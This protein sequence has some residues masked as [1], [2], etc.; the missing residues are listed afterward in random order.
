MHAHG[1]SHTRVPLH[2]LLLILALP[3]AVWPSRSKAEIVLPYIISDGMVLQRDAAVA[4]WG[5][6]GADARLRVSFHGISAEARA[7]AHGKWSLRL[8]PMRAAGDPA[9]LTITS[10]D[11]R[12]AARRIENVLVGDVWLC[13]GQ[14]NMYCP[15]GKIAE[16]PGAEGGE[17]AI[18][19]PPD[20]QLRLIC[21]DQAPLWKQRGWQP[22]SP[23]SRFPF[24]AVAYFFGARLRR[25]LNVPIGL[26]NVS[27]GGSAIQRW[28][29]PAYAERVPITRQLNGVFNRE[30][31][32][33]AAYNRQLAA[34][35]QA[36]REGR[37]RPDAPA[38]M[39]AELMA[40]RSFSGAAAYERLITPLVP[41][42]LRGVIWYQGESNS[43]QLDVAQSYADM[44]RAMVDGWRDAWDAPELPFYIVQLPCWKGGEFWQWTRQSQ[45]AAS[46]SIPHCGM[47]VCTDIG[48]T[49]LLHPPQKQP[50]GDRLAAIALARTYGRRSIPCSGPTVSQIATQQQAGGMAVTIRFDAADGAPRAKGTAWQDVEIA[51]ADGVFYPA[52]VTLEADRATA[53]SPR[54]PAPVAI[55]YGWRAVFSP[56]LFNEAGLPASGFYYVR[57]ARGQWS[58]YLPKTE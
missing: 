3:S 5:T 33:I 38:T 6:A 30:R 17:A 54:V 23:E 2:V 24:S 57:D 12:D 35:E 11:A 22:A 7:D 29:P 46:R 42:T 44:L 18:A 13:S 36:S 49:S 25:E 16:Y 56:S 41:F 27:R 53:R 31:A 50:V 32:R 47:V 40:A 14:S 55:R 20:R 8:P 10:S 9:V 4:I 21:D 51:G 26:I 52:T 58:L 15:M 28:T 43:G 1:R 39:P 37:P 45:F 48:D 19:A 34:R